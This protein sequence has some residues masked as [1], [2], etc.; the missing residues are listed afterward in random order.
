MR[1]FTTCLRV[2]LLFTVLSAMVFA[3]TAAPEPLA[4]FAEPA[5][6]PDKT[7][8]AFV[9]G[10]DIWTA[11]VNG[12]EARLLVSHPA[13]D[14]RP[15]YSPDGK[16]LAFMSSRA[17]GSDIYTL[18]FATGE[19]KRMTFDDGNELLDAWSRDGQWLYF[20]ANARDIGGMNDVYRVSA[21][22]GTPMQF[23]RDRYVSEFFSAPAPDGLGVAFTA[24]GNSATQW[25]RRGH[26]HLDEAEIWIV[27]DGAYQQVTKRG[28]K[29]MWPMWAADGKSLYYVSDRGGAQNIWTQTPGGAARQVTK[30]TD[31]RVL[32]PNIS[33]DGAVIV[34]ERDFGVWKLE[35]KTGQ[36]AEIRITRRGAAP[37]PNV[38]HMSVGAQLQELALSPDGKKVAFV[39]RGEIFAASAKDGGDA[40]RVTREAARDAQIA[41]APDSKRIAYVSERAAAGQLFLYDFTSNS[42]TALTGN[43]L[44]DAAPRFS[45]DG[46]SLVY[47]RDTRELRV[48]DV[49]T[50]DDRVLASG[51]LN[52]TAAQSGPVWSPDGQWIA[53]TA[54]SARAFRNIYVVPAAGGEP[55][56]VSFL[57]NGFLGGL[58]WSPDGTY[59]IFNSS[60]RTEESLLAR[61]DLILRTPKFREDQFRDL[62][63]EEPARNRP[64]GAG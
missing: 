13:S 41:W 30:F 64:G 40:V 19:L 1:S 53:Y 47:V 56:A 45:P 35:T 14:S 21:R 2:A 34:F 23:S 8:I 44:R 9:S 57:P 48:I 63:R 5:I 18:T 51:Q 27:R 49:A 29:E 39:A 24:R 28:A 54:V 52:V 37:G 33:A 46:K 61:V 3:Q 20:S 59:I 55:R 6:S 10:G 16:R 31:G 7:E 12:G 62:F 11:P 50:K 17:G 22:G 15:L 25:W 60:Q 4:S 36:A 58:S 38:E 43:A 42:E 26:S 32:W